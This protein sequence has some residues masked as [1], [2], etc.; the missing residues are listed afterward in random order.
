MK[1]NPGRGG[2]ETPVSSLVTSTGRRIAASRDAGRTERRASFGRRTGEPGGGNRVGRVIRTVVLAVLLTCAA[3]GAGVPAGAVTPVP[4]AATNQAAVSSAN[5]S[6]GERLRTASDTTANRSTAAVSKP[7]AGCTEITAGGTYEVADFTANVPS[8]GCIVINTTS[9]VTLQSSKGSSVVGGDGRGA[10]ISIASRAAAVEVVDVGVDNWRVGV[11]ASYVETVTLTGVE[12]SAVDVGVVAYG[13]GE[14]L[15]YRTSVDDASGDAIDGRVVTSLDV[16]DLE[17]NGADAAL[18]ATGTVAPGAIDVDDVRARDLR[19]AALDLGADGQSIDVDGLSVTNATSGV[20]VTGTPAGAVT[21]VTVENTSVAV[22]A[23]DDASEL[24]FEDV[25]LA[26]EPHYG[27]GTAVEVTF[28]V[29][30]ARVGTV[31]SPPSPRIPDGTRNGT[32]PVRVEPNDGPTSFLVDSDPVV[33]DPLAG[34]VGAWAYDGGTW[35]AP[36]G[37]VHPSNETVR[38][39]PTGASTLGVFSRQSPVSTCGEF[40]APGDYLIEPIKSDGAGDCL[41]VTH[42]DVTLAGA[43]GGSRVVGVGGDAV[44]V[45]A[46]LENVVVENLTLSGW[47]RGVNATGTGAV[48]VTGV[49]VQDPAAAG[50][51]ARG[52]TGVALRDVSVH[53]GRGVGL[54]VY[55]ADTVFAEDLRVANLAAE[56]GGLGDPGTGLYAG[57][58]VDAPDLYVDDVVVRN[59]TRGVVVDGNGTGSVRNVATR[60]VRTTVEVTGSRAERLSFER[61]DTGTATASFTA[62]DAAVGPAAGPVSP[63]TPGIRE[64]VTGHLNVTGTAAGSYVE[65][66]YGANLPEVYEDSLYAGPYDEG[67][68]SWGDTASVDAANETLRFEPGDGSEL[69]GV[70]AEQPPLTSC[71]LLDAPG[72]YEV[73]SFAGPVDDFEDCLLIDAD[74][75]TLRGTPGA[76]VTGNGSGTG[77]TVLT[78]GSILSKR[79]NVSVRNLAVERYGTGLFA[80][81][82]LTI[83]GARIADSTYGAFVDDVEDGRVAI[84]NTTVENTSD[85]GIYTDRA[86]R[87]TLEDV[88]LRRPQRTGV[89]LTDVSRLTVDGLDVED[90]ADETYLGATL[91]GTGLVLGNARGDVRDVTVENASRGVALGY[92]PPETIANVSTTDVDEAVYSDVNNSRV[93]VRNL[94]TPEGRAT[95]VGPE[96]V[97]VSP[98]AVAGTPADRPVR[99][100]VVNVTGTTDRA[101]TGLRFRFDPAAADAANLSVYQYDPATGGWVAF[102]GAVDATNGTIAVPVSSASAST[103]VYGAFTTARDTTAP[104]AEAGPDR[105][106]QPGEAVTFDA[107]NST[108]DGGIASYDWDLGDGTTATGERVTHSYAG[109]STYR[110][111]LTVADGAGNVDT[112]SLT[113]TVAPACPTVDGTRATDPTDD[114]LCEDVDGSGAAGFLDVVTLL[115]VDPSSLTRAEERAFDFDGDGRL[116]FLDVVDLLFRV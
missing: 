45:D 52:A 39:T 96:Y 25:D 42:D 8:G 43:E 80:Q 18:D 115:F 93:T 1:Q 40:D 28:N 104:V 47:T 4:V 20:N 34:A 9:P 77:I 36:A 30:N 54:N 57:G 19:K 70:F 101:R 109:E 102:G 99:L 33:A 71:G 116:G 67:S 17:V 62:S 29:S 14:A 106:V 10:A 86:G 78:K 87:V 97:S 90:V 73:D 69:Y 46:G 38:F 13:T 100:G 7:I 64:N 51:L 21:N 59:A 60:D 110:V 26:V 23:F 114:G 49:E 76:T 32:G 91:P 56:G 41:R 103:D 79:E 31:Q 88:T 24:R 2:P 83:A 65:I 81:G 35:N 111:N 44:A 94:S 112:D 15:V 37:A 82:S 75:V 68:N 61:I 89:R 105:T 63:P 58:G 92:S 66:D 48:T 53:D 22:A 50:V 85:L 84:R 74:D 98:S 72:V 108:D 113:V 12:A 6:T 95:I 5:E 16:R 11:D 27:T 55:R 3:A 107:G